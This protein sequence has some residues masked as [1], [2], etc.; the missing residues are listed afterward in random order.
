MSELTRALVKCYS[1]INFPG[2]TFAT[3]NRT[4]L[5]STVKKIIKVVINMNISVGSQRTRWRIS[6]LCAIENIEDLP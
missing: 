2:T 4:N 3:Y 6:L 5:H 1:F